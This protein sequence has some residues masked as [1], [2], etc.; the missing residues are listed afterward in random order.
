[1]YNLIYSKILL[2]LKINLWKIIFFLKLEFDLIVKKID[3]FLKVR[4]M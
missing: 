3:C 4:H 1:M 2:I